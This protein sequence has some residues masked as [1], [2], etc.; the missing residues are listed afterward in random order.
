MTSEFV[1][2]KIYR[3]LEKIEARLT[4][5]EGGWTKKEIEKASFKPLPRIAPFPQI[6]E[7]IYRLNSRGEII[8]QTWTDSR[9][10]NDT[11]MFMGVYKTREE[12]QMVRAGIMTF[13]SEQGFGE[14]SAWSF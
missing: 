1:L 7:T 5:L 11:R 4:N 3:Q 14:D 13:V 6:G 12:A 10:Q 2:N 9:K 8:E